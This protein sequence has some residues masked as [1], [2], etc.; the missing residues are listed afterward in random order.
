MQEMSAVGK[1]HDASQCPRAVR[2]WT[3]ST[4]DVNT[5][6]AHCNDRDFDTFRWQLSTD[7]VREAV[8]DDP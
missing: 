5:I 4:Y 7:V 3:H 1:F 2:A 6:A 8:H